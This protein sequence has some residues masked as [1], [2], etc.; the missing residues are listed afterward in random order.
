MQGGFYKRETEI[1][2]MTGLDSATRKVARER[3]IKNRV[4]CLVDHT[5]RAAGRKCVA[6]DNDERRGFKRSLTFIVS[7]LEN[8][9]ALQTPP[10]ASRKP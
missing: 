1:D 9:Q 8:S 4:R 5:P 7:R 3:T 6:N 10:E 2:V